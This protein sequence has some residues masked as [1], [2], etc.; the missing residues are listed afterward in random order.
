MKVGDIVTMKFTKDKSTYKAP[1]DRIGVVIE[2]HEW[3][4]PSLFYFMPDEVLSFHNSW[5][6]SIGRR[7]VVLWSD[8][9]KF[10]SVPEKYY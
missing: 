9:L 7:I 2:A 4:N 10:T 3:K 5:L 6:E 1:E 8:S